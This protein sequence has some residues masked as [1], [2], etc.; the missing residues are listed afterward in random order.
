MLML[1]LLHLMLQLLLLQLMLVLLL[2]HR[3]SCCNRCSARYL[4]AKRSGRTAIEDTAIASAATAHWIAAARIH[5]AAAA[6]VLRMCRGADVRCDLTAHMWTHVWK[7]NCLQTKLV[8]K[9]LNL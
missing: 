9:E 7:T 1:L 6:H 2:G 8:I 5:S 3:S 4:H